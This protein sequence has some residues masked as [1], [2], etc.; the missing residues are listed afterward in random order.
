MQAGADYQRKVTAFAQA[1]DEA[2]RADGILNDAKKVAQNVWN[3]LTNKKYI[4]AVDFTNGFAGDLIEKHKSILEK[5]ANRLSGEAKT[6]EARY[7]KSPGG[8]PEAKFQEE[9]RHSKV[10]GAS[11]LESDAETFGR[12]VAS[13]IP[14]IGW[15]ITAAGIG[16][17]IHEGKPPGKAIFSGV[18]GTLAAMGVAAMVPGVGWAAAAG[19]GAGLVVGVGADWAYDHLV[20]DGVKHKIDDGL[21]DIGHG[22]EN[23]GKSVGHFFTSI[24]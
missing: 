19:I 12:R 24:F 6:A 23:A 2:N 14:I 8:S 4:N 3:D 1:K 17:D 22:A 5:E 15:G 7:L 21:K 9:T 20:P 10:L 11:E 18:T 13:K 16:Y